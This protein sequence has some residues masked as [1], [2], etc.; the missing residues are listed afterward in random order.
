MEM[1][2][3]GYYG[4]FLCT[5]DRCT[6]SCCIGWE[7]DVDEATLA[8]YDALAG[9]RGERIR[10]SILRSD[11]GACFALCQD[12]R[13]PHLED[14]G[15]C[16]IICEL[17]EDYLCDICRE[18]P[19]F[20]NVVGE[21][22]ECGLGAVC[23]EAARLI[24]SWQDYASLVR[25]GS[26]ENGQG[27]PCAFDAVA[28]RAQLYTLLSDQT[29]PYAERLVR[30]RADFAAPMM[31][32]RD[33]YEEMLCSLEYMN[34]ASRTLFL[35]TWERGVCEGE[36]ATLC[37]RFLAYAVYRHTSAASDVQAFGEGVRAALYMEQIFCALLC[38]HGYDAVRAAQLVSEELE[39]SEANTATLRGAGE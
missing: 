19:R 8:L 15:L 31:L 5:A 29:L 21:R 6:H 38:R 13:C 17:G 10:G 24:L 9:E 34:P 36:A 1:V 20:Y 11:D 33:E 22:L 23:E 4:A 37:E 18:H 25:I 39:Y 14:T 16:R 28:R 3:P 27:T 7:I 30:I 32:S 2:A 35:D 12:G 26:F